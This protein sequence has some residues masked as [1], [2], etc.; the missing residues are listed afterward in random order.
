MI[1]FLNDAQRSPAGGVL[2][3]TSLAV[4][5]GFLCQGY[6]LCVYIM[7]HHGTISSGHDLGLASAHHI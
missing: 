4:L 3:L 2:A 1:G 7:I 6:V 5:P